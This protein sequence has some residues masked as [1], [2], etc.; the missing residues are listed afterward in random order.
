MLRMTAH[1]V[2]VTA[3]QLSI[4]NR[5]AFFTVTYR[6]LSYNNTAQVL[7]VY[8]PDGPELARKRSV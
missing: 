8:A 7:L 5:E 3:Q 2:T 6:H 4:M 1:L